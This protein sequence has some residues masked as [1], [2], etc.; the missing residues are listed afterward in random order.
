MK[1]YELFESQLSGVI[2][3]A[4]QGGTHHSGKTPRPAV[5]VVDSPVKLRQAELRKLKKDLARAIEDESYEVAAK[6]R[7][8]IKSLENE[9]D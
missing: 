5:P 7:D 6:L 4:Q 1:D 3:R 2:E 8:Q 9:R